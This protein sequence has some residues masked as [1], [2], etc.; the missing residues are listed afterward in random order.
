MSSYHFDLEKAIAAWRR[1]LEQNRAFS[2]DDLEE[3]ESSLR[4]RVDALTEAGLSEEAAFNEA[5]RRMGTYGAAEEEYRKVYWGKITRQHQWRPELQWRLSML[6]NYLVVAL[7][8]LLRQKGYSFI[9]IVGLAVGIACCLVVFLYVLDE[10]SYDQFHEELEHLYR[11]HEVMGETGEEWAS[12][13]WAV[14]EVLQ[15]TYGD[16]VEV[17]R[18]RRHGPGVVGEVTVRRGNRMFI[19][20]NLFYADSTIFDVLTFPLIAGDHDRVLARPRD[21]VLTEAMAAKYFGEEDPVGQTILLSD[22]PFTVT[23]IL[24]NPLEHSHLQFG[25]LASMQSTWNPSPGDGAP[26]R[27]DIYYTYVKVSDPALI[28]PLQETLRTHQRQ[29]TSHTSTFTFFPV[30]DIHLHSDNERELFA[31]GDIRRV[32]LFLVIGVFLLVIACINFVSL[33]TARSADRAREVGVRKVLGANR[34][35]LIRQFFTEALLLTLAAMLLAFVLT[36]GML[37][38]LNGLSGN[39]LTLQLT[40][41]WWMPLFLLGIVLGVGLLAGSYPAL[42]LSAL[43]PVRVLKGRLLGS[44]R[45]LLRQGLVVTQFTLSTLLIVGTLVVS[46]QL[47][48]LHRAD[49]GLDKDQVL[50]LSATNTYKLGHHY[51]VLKEELKKLPGMQ[52]ITTSDVVPGERLAVRYFAPEGRSSEDSLVGLRSLIVDEEFVETYGLQVIKGKGFSGTVGRGDQRAYILNE[53]A[54]RA[55]GWEQP[56][57]KR[58]GEGEVIGIVRDFHYA[59]LH[60]G[61]E[62]M[63]MTNGGGHSAISIKLNTQDLSRLLSGIERIWSEVIPHEPFD[64]S[65][66]DEGFDQL[67]RREAALQQAVGY[68]TILAF[69]IACLGLF[70]LAA[71]T[72][73][74]RTKEIGIRK[75]L[76]A[77]ITSLVALLSSDFLKLVGLAFVV[78]APVGYF[79]MQH[80]L[81]GFAYRIA[82]GPGV[83]LATG[84][85]VALIVVLTVSYQAIKAALA[86]P[87]KSV[88]YE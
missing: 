67:Y 68:A 50:V 43:Q 4:D 65:F 26:W 8:N 21:V 16:R 57:G 28:P 31:N 83:F 32:Y 13:P 56:V 75:I 70:G 5:L 72:A 18:L 46:R 85:L 69:F 54:V 58:I 29:Q 44:Q 84:G 62:P 59:S 34:S 47:D 40:R 71:F 48:F 14:A 63:I 7:R 35:Q 74:Q 19:E 78:A 52:H 3:L 51:A 11:V 6:K 86:D 36:W 66:L 1:P 25:F 20:E 9:N 2:S 53:A 73:E 23:G 38:L 88:R 81:D 12:A 10:L 82:I 37:P 55:L 22:V 17:A 60:H 30:A 39:S 61:V 27:F 15:Q 64:F 80:W 87:V 42:Y 24:N 33:A 79:V 41:P 49:L 77:S 45:A 76:G